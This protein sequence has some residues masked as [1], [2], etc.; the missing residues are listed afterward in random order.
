MY[1]VRKSLSPEREYLPIEAE[2]GDFVGVVE[3]RGASRPRTGVLIVVGSVA[4]MSS[5]GA[6]GNPVAASSDIALENRSGPALNAQIDGG[7]FY[8]SSWVSQ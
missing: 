1:L 2:F 7:L 5:S 6:C 3:C 4:M 8:F